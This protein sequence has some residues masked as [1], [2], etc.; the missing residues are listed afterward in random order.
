MFATPK[1]VLG[2]RAQ[3]RAARLE[4]AALHRIE[5]ALELGE[6]AR[7]EVDSIAERRGTLPQRLGIVV[8]ALEPVLQR[9]L[10]GAHAL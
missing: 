2:L 7:Q 4:R 9:T 1:V 8:R 10:L 5:A 3:Q 6:T